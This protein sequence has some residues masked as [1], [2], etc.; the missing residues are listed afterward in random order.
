MCWLIFI[1]LSPCN[2]CIINV[3]FSDHKLAKKKDKKDLRKQRRR[4]RLEEK[5][6]LIEENDKPPHLQIPETEYAEGIDNI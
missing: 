2:V 6:D 5:D 3:Y 4:E 1:W